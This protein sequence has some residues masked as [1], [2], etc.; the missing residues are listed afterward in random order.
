MKKAKSS[1]TGRFVRGPEVPAGSRVEKLVLNTYF[2]PTI[3]DLAG[4]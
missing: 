4:I 1:M 2:A 3:A